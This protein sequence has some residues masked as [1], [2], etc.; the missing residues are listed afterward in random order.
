MIITDA[1]ALSGG[2]E[3]YYTSSIH[4]MFKLP[5]QNLSK[6]VSTK[7]GSK[8]EHDTYLC[9]V[10]LELALGILN[11]PI[12][13]DGFAEPTCMLLKS[14]AMLLASESSSSWRSSSSLKEQKSYH[15]ET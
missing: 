12:P 1:T 6:N 13:I 15:I 4:L 2:I 7:F 5:S 10:K 11:L 3:Y 9:V 8:R 14:V